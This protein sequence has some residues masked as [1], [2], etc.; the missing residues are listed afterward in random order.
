MEKNKKFRFW[1]PNFAWNIGAINFLCQFL[2]EFSPFFA[3]VLFLMHNFWTLQTK[4]LPWALE[5]GLIRYGEQISKVLNHNLLTI[6]KTQQSE[7]NEVKPEVEIMNYAS[8]P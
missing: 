3:K 4:E 7:R 5:M 2:L 1:E 8:F 6:N